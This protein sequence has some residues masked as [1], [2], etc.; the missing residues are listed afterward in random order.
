MAETSKSGAPSV[1]LSMN[2]NIDMQ[3]KAKIKGRVELSILFVMPLV[4]FSNLEYSANIMPVAERNS[5][6]M[7]CQPLSPRWLSCLYVIAQPGRK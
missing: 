3:L 4:H 7:T 6:G 1:K 5:K 2:L